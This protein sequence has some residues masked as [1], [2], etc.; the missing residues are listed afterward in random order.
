MQRLSVPT[1]D[2]AWVLAGDQN[3]AHD[4]VGYLWE[5]LSDWEW[6]IRHEALPLFKPIFQS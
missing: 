4:N 2:G 5:R 6:G 3:P 1:S